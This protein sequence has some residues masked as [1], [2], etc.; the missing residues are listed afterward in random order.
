MHRLVMTAFLATLASCSSGSEARITATVQNVTYPQTISGDVALRFALV[1][2]VE[3]AVDVVI[4]VSL[5]HGGSWRGARIEGALTGLSATPSGTYHEV[6]WD[7]LA[8]AGFRMTHGARLRL[9]PRSAA[10]RG[11]TVQLLLPVADNEAAAARAVR[12]YFIHYG[13]FDA[14]TEAV[15]KTHDLVIL[16]PH[17]GRLSVEVVQRIQLGVDPEDPADDVLVLAYIS[18]GE[19][20]RTIYFTDAEMLLDPRFVGDGS[21]PRIDP[22]G[23]YADGQSLA[24]IDPLGAPSNGGTG[25]ASWYLD[26]N[27]V[28]RDPNDIGDGLPDRNAYFGGCFVNAGDPAWFDVLD[29]MTVDGA[30]G[31]QG[32]AELLTTDFGRGYGCDGLFLDTIDTCAPNI[33]TNSSSGNQSE[34]EWT[35]PGFTA[36]MHRLKQ[37]Y[38]DKL[39]LQNRGLFFFDK[40]RAHYDCTSRGAI[41]FV[42]FES[43]RLNSNG[44]QGFD[45]YYFPDNKHNVM[46]KLMAEANRPDGFRVLSLGYAEGPPEEMSVQT[47]VGGSTLGMASLIEDIREAEDV[48]GFRHYLT[49]H[50]IGFANT[51]VRDNATTGPD[52]TAPGW[53]STYN[54]NAHPWPTPAG[55]PVPRIGI[56]DVEPGPDCVTVRWDVALDLNRVGYVLYYKPGAFDFAGDPGLT[57]A[58]RVAV[59][60]QLS[61]DYGVFAGHPYQATVTGLQTGTSYSFLVRAVD[62]AGNEDGNQVALTAVP[63]EQASITIDGSFG[64]WA[65]VPVLHQDPADVPASAGPDWLTVQIANDDDWLYLRFTS[66]DPFN[67]DGSPTYGYSRT[68]VFID[69]D[70]DPGTGYAASSVVGSEFLIAGGSLYGQ[71]AGVWNT[72][73]LGAL[74]VLPTTNV[75]DWEIAVPLSTIRDAVPDASRLRFRM[76]ND[77]AGDIAPETGAVYYRLATR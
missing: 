53:S 22:R 73:L 23:P 33:Y 12:D 39:V 32:I 38:P 64:D 49:D 5:D 74:S 51:F 55:P 17:N 36:F 46:P 6:T 2:E 70:N 52:T 66:E 26:D 76:V 56:Q 62:E 16:H 1:D 28:D 11:D 54:V 58:T 65:A 24:N 68:L 40:R 19:D 25:Y 20:V 7:S 72:G 35:A 41:D 60:P 27:S 4:E 3:S 48:A 31:V 9:Y 63:F 30:D 75:T 57:A 21:G 18:V 29:T 10:G 47:L 14:H 71:S 50:G 34:F 61:T 8:D 69:A 13:E 59:V 44:F 37:R 45:P 15:A 43:Y 67:L 77:D 42:L